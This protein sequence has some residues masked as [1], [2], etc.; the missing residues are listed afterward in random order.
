MT[1]KE[2]A[3]K[4]G[5]SIAWVHGKISRCEIP[6]NRMPGQWAW[7]IDY[8][9]A[10]EWLA[11]AEREPKRKSLGQCVHELQEYN[12]QHGTAYSYGERTSRGII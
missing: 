12:K 8:N 10:L 11:E 3:E 1:V 5:K 6:R 2:F 4:M 7:D 9:E